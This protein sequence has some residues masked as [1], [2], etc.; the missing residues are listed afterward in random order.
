LRWMRAGTSSAVSG[1]WSRERMTWLAVL[2]AILTPIV[3]VG[4]Y[5]RYVQFTTQVVGGLLIAG[6]FLVRNPSTPTEKLL[7]WLFLWGAAWLMIGLFLEPSEGGIKKAPETLTYFF[8]VT[9]LTTLLL[10]SLSAITDGLKRPQWES[11][12]VDVG[13]N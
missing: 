4:M 11:T 6:L 2:A 13:H 7:R 5:T 1:A 12:L 3:V 9:G 8:T 10:V